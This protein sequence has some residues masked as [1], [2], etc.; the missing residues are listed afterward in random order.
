MNQSFGF[1]GRLFQLLALIVASST[2][3]ANGQM[4]DADPEASNALAE[5]VLAVRSAPRAAT[6]EVVVTTRQGDLEVAAPAR[7][8]QWTLIPD[9]GLRETR[10]GSQ[11]T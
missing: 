8:L 11:Q 5:L 4:R 1:S 2:S 10:Q 9:Q 3:P 7:R 6:E